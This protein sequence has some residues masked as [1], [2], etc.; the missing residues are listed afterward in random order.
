MFG[1]RLPLLIFRQNGVSGG[2]FDNGVTDVFVHTIPIETW[3]PSDDIALKEVFL[4]WHA[5]VQEHY[6]S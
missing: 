3:I 4:K 5:K 6:Y 2:V 1:L